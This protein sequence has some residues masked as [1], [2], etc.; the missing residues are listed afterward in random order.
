MKIN[1]ICYSLR[2]NNSYTRNFIYNSATL[3]YI[4]NNTHI[5][6]YIYLYKR[7][8]FT[9]L[10]CEMKSIFVELKKKKISSET[11]VAYVTHLHILYMDVVSI[12]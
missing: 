9:S 4:M 3:K 5:Y 6:I 12:L 10:I 7:D 11:V 1:K 8:L 2:Y